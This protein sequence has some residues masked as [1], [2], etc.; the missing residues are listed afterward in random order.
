VTEI[1]PSISSLDIYD[2]TSKNQVTKYNVT[3]EYSFLILQIPSSIQEFSRIPYLQLGIFIL[4]DGIIT[5]SDTP[6]QPLEDFLSTFT[7]DSTEYK[8]TQKQ[9][10]SY[11]LY[12]IFSIIQTV[13]S[14]RVKDTLSYVSNVEQL[15]LDPLANSVR[16]VIRARTHIAYMR[17][18]IVPLLQIVE[19]Y[20]KKVAQNKQ[21]SSYYRDIRDHLKKAVAIINE[22]KETIE[23]Y[24]DSDYIINTEE[25]NRIL[26]ILT[27]AFTFSIPATLLGTFY[28]MN[29]PLPGGTETGPWNL[30]GPYTTFL[31]IIFISVVV[32]YAMFLYFK[33]KR[34][35]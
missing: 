1:F 15:V 10:P 9:S 32:A 12:K 21:M 2:C 19:E 17:R 4:K 26:S 22:A 16:E 14:S 35:I 28:G 30:F 11:L 23:I 3:D 24:K 31:I 13:V 5:I 27:I 8:K 18:M 7:E 29:I 20:Q 34:W 25:A 33:Y 6:F